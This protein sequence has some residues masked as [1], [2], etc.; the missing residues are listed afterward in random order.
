MQEPI[1]ETECDLGT[2]VYEKPTLMG[3]GWAMLD[4]L[5]MAIFLTGAL[6]LM[7]ISAGYQHATLE[8]I[9]ILAIALILLERWIRYWLKV[10]HPNGHYE[11]ERKFVKDGK[12]TV[13]VGANVIDSFPKRCKWSA[14]Q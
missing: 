11:Y 2:L 6:Y 4:I 3:F 8:S 9:A 13:L 1:D 12:T 10:T 7:K 5:M 14:G